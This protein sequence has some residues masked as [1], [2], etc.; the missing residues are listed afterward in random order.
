M[1]T[2]V[3]STRIIAAE[4]PR[5]SQASNEVEP[6][7]N[8]ALTSNEVEPR[9]GK[10]KVKRELTLED[11]K[12]RNKQRY[13]DLIERCRSGEYMTLEERK[14]T[15]Y[16]KVK[17]KVKIDKIPKIKVEE[18]K[19]DRAIR[20]NEKNRKYRAAHREAYNHYM[21]EMMKEKYRNDEDYRVRQLV[22]AKQRRETRQ[23]SINTNHII[24][25]F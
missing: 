1:E 6:Q 10:A 17:V 15:A 4:E 14:D 19:E 7:Q 22:M 11:K 12:Q 18:T 16:V 9:T 20:L 2:S 23:K 5:Q 21:C 24:S 13:L 8:R 3:K 25:C